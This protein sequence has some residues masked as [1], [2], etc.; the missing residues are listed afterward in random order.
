[1]AGADVAAVPPP[2]GHAALLRGEH[3][4]QDGAVD[5]EPVPDG[6]D[7]QQPREPGTSSERPP[8]LEQV[9]AGVADHVA[10][11]AVQREAP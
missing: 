7:L 9:P 4:L 10:G 8:R 6:D 11:D 2:V 1:M 3:G 5:L